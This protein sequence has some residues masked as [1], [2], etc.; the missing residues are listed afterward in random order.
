MEDIVVR[1]RFK[2]NLFAPLNLYG[3]VG[4]QAY[5]A[6]MALPGRRILVSVST[7]RAAT[8]QPALISN[9][10]YLTRNVAPKR[11]HLFEQQYEELARISAH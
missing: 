9:Q 10:L 11:R 3:A 6:G 4:W 8:L 1:V 2:E 7:F 5:A